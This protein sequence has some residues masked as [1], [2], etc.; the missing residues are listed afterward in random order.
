MST[1]TFAPEYYKG[2]KISFSVKTNKFRAR[3][4]RKVLTSHA[5]LHILKLSIDAWV[6]N[7]ELSAKIDATPA[8]KSPNPNAVRTYER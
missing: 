6:D 3:Y 1:A 8:G 2:Y 4:G 7:K 5:D